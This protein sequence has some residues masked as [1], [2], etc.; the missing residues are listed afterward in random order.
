MGCI[1]AGIGDKNRWSQYTLCGKRKTLPDILQFY[2]GN[3]T[4]AECLIRQDAMFER[5][6]QQKK[7]TVWYNR[8]GRQ[9]M[10]LFD[11]YHAENAY[12]E[13]TFKYGTLIIPRNPT[14]V[15][16]I[17]MW[18]TDTIKGAI[19]LGKIGAHNMGVSK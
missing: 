16:E 15:R 8:E 12:G 2:A 1:I 5:G 4:C 10:V 19:K 18:D 11:V 17:L 7:Y 13:R 6:Y 14:F 9:N 3:I